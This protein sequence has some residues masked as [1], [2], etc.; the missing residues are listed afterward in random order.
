MNKTKL[1]APAYYRDFICI[2]DRCRHSC[3]IGWEIDVDGDTMCLYDTLTEGYG[4]CVRASIDTESDLNTPHFRLREGDRCPHL[5]ESGLCRIITE[6]GEGYL[7]EICREHPRFYHDTPYGKEVGLGMACEE[8][9]RIILESDGYDTFEEIETL[10]TAADNAASRFD[11]IAHRASIYGV[12][13]N[14]AIPY[15]ER[16][17][18]IE[19]VYGV[20]P[21]ALPDSA[22]HTVLDRLEYLDE[23]HRALFGRYTSALPLSAEDERALERA[24][25]YF[26]FR[27][28][29]PARNE[30]DFRAAVGFSLL[31]ERLLASVSDHT[32]GGIREAARIVSEELEYS[33]DNTAALT[34]VFDKFGH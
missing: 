22:W 17:L 18:R 7:C 34:Q 14:R 33:E 24:L 11:A 6:L 30:R 28:A 1:Y 23:G 32:D 31:C 3:C 9:C 8:A 27:H 13:S 19:D 5:D 16:L 21:S 25:A 4:A 10:N 12:L 15:S 26:I 29:S 20:A 2:A